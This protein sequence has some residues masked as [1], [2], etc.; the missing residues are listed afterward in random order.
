VIA[1]RKELPT[2]LVARFRAFTAVLDEIEPGKAGLAD[3][4]PGTRLPGRPLRDAVE[5]YRRRL[6]D[7]RPVMSSW[8]CPE[9][10][11][12]WRACD[13]GLDQ[14]I[15]RAERVLAAPHDPEGFERLLGTVEQ[16]L[17]P[18]EPF[19]AAEERFRRLRRRAPRTV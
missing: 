18:L 10:D 13:V 6:G 1:R 17:D 15:A 7:A 19:A 14:A 2:H 5:E 12:E 16:L 11:D 9:L 8:R 4:L 3:V